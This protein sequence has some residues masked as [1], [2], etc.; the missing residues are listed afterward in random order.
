MKRDFSGKIVILAFCV[1]WASMPQLQSAE[2]AAAA[3]TSPQKSS[4][5][6][7]QDLFSSQP[8]KV[9]AVADSLEYQK[10]TGKLIAR[11]NAVIS[12]EGTRIVADYAEVESD[13]KKAYAKGH[14]MIFRGTEPRLQGEEIYY[15]FSDHTGTFPNARAM[16]DPW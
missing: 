10:N 8:A 11:G 13:A 2:P 16:N 7:I 3:K 12:Y 4:R 9:E 1:F 14:V 6:P 5:V 15:D